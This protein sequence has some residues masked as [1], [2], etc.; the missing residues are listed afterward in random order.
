METLEKRAET[1][2][3]KDKKGEQN[4]PKKEEGVKVNLNE[5]CVSIYEIPNDIC[6]KLYLGIK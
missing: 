3:A 2:A 5:E 6:I 1:E 4:C